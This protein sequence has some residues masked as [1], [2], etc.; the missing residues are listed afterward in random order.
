[1]A[2]AQVAALVPG[3]VRELG[4]VLGQEQELA[5]VPG[6][7]R[8]PGLALA[9]APVRRAAAREREETALPRAQSSLLSRLSPRLSSPPPS[10][11]P[12]RTW[13]RA[14]SPRRNRE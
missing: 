8:G 2:A 11:S 1:M 14:L 7:A 9:P 10:I 6:P 4:Q 3:R 13:P 5:V 12:A